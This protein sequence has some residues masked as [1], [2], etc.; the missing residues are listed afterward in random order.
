LTEHA[1]DI[2]T[3]A[4]A[5]GRLRYAS[6]GLRNS[7]GYTRE[8]CQW[9]S[10]FE[11]VHPSD[12]PEVRAQFEQLV[13]GK[14]DHFLKEVRVRHKDG[15]Y[16]WLESS[17]VSAL[18]NP[19][20]GG[21][22]INS[23]DITER[24]QAE[25]RLAQREDVF[26]LGADAVDGVVFEW[27]L[28]RGIVQRSRGVKEVLGIVPE[29]LEPTVDA[30][31]ERMHPRD[32][33]KARRAVRIALLQG[34]GWTV[35]YRIRDARGHYKSILERGLIQRNAAG[36]PVRAIGTCV[37]IS[38]IS[39]L[40]TSWRRAS[41]PRRSVAGSTTLTPKTWRGPTSCIASSMPI[42]RIRCP[43]RR[44]CATAAR[45]SRASAC[46]RRSNMHSAATA[47]WI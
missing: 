35:T 14:I 11:Y 7:L 24:K 6:G 38:E 42:L 26:R 29:D 18:D 27:D 16:R 31:H 1:R 39:A 10:I 41:G 12:Y 37:D 40:P 36:D 34:R 8:E 17:Y 32:F 15:T 44:R 22:V 43:R 30:W 47:R 25:F 33:D 28:V 5:E 21:V 13:A 9:N 46:G 19:L 45:R 2:I 4:D 3:V 20:I 23:R